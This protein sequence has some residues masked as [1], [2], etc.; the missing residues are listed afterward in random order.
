MVKSSKLSDS[1]WLSSCGF[2][3]QEV[4]NWLKLVLNQRD[5]N[6]LL[7]SPRPP[8]PPPSISSSSLANFCL[9]FINI[10]GRTGKTW[11]KNLLPRNMTQG[12]G[13]DAFNAESNTLTTIFNSNFLVVD[14]FFV[15]LYLNKSSLH[16]SSFS[17]FNGSIH[18][19]YNERNIYI[20]VLPPQILGQAWK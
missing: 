20:S 9:A 12:L 19:S 10:P 1:Y 13:P 16:V 3:E 7:V 6:P 17:S 2:L 15:I 5:A 4:T 14:L 11:E 18:K 8:L